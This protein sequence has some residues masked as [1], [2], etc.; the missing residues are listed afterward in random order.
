MV[1]SIQKGK[2]GE[3]ELAHFLQ[4][5]G[6]N[7]A[8]RGRQYSGLEGKDVV[9]L[10]GIHSECKRVEQLNILK[11]MKQS[12]KDSKIDEL[13]TVMHRKNREE[14]LVTMR[15]EDWLLLYKGYLAELEN[16]NIEK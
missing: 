6:F 1:K 16:R 2:D 11:A 15:L 9:G 7:E 5:H 10:P 4:D 13:P 8:R 12:I 3:L 14:W